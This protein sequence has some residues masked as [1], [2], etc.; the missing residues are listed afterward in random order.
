MKRVG[1][2]AHG[3]DEAR[4]WDIEQVAAMTPD[5]RHRVAKALQDRFYG[6]NRPDVRD[7]FAGR[8][9]KMRKR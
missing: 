3:H 5:E 8:R 1:H 6:P 4:A 9:Y 7:S 2:K